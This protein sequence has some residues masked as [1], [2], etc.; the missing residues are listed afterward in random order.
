M[1]PIYSYIGGSFMNDEDLVKAAQNGDVE[2][3]YKLIVDYKDKLYNTSYCYLKSEQDTLE[4]IQEVTCRAYLKINKLKEP[5][6]FNTWLT[7]IMINYCIDEQKRKK[8][9]VFIEQVQVVNYNNNNTDNFCIED[10]LEKLQP[11]YKEVIILKYIQDMTIIDI[12]KVMECP[13][14]TIKTWISRGLKQL[15]DLLNVGGNFNV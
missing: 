2:A 5:R 1:A 13:E 15:K 4:A 8:K 9:V 12:S 3:F 6:Y 7:R 11:K 14:G 10:A